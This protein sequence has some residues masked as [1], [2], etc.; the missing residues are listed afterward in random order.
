[1]NGLDLAKD[2]TTQKKYKWQVKGYKMALIDFGIKKNILRLLSNTGCELTV[3]P[4]SIKAED[5]LSFEP[6][7]VF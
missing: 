7:G 2:V 1:M 3:F 6:D 5:I 4:A